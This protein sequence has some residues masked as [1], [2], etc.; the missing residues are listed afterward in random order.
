MEN[1]SER[2]TDHCT[3]Y[4]WKLKSGNEIKAEE[5]VKQDIVH[6]IEKLVMVTQQILFIWIDTLYS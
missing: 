1:G 3:R 4:V 2:L 5:H 6:E